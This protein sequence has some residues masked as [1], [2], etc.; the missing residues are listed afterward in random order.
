MSFVLIVARNFIHNDFIVPEDEDAASFVVLE[1]R[2][3]NKNQQ[4]ESVLDRAVAHTY[5]PKADTDSNRN[6]ILQRV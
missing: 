1:H 6:K 5:S 3:R 2:K 4:E